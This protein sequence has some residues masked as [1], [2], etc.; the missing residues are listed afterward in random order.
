MSG[1]ARHCVEKWGK[2]IVS[3]ININLK[4]ELLFSNENDRRVSAKIIVAN[5]TTNVTK[6]RV[7]ETPVNQKLKE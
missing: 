4:L 1:K 3:I 2:K 7:I 6:P 5:D